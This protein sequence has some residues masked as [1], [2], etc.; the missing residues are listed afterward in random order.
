MDFFDKFNGLSARI[1]RQRD[2]V[3]TE[4]VAKTAFVLPFLRSLGC[5]LF[6][7]SI[8]P[9]TKT[10]DRV[11]PLAHAGCLNFKKNRRGRVGFSAQSWIWPGYS[12]LICLA[13]IK[14]ISLLRLSSATVIPIVFLS[15]IDYGILSLS[16]ATP[17]PGGRV[18][19]NE[20]SKFVIRDS[21][22]QGALCA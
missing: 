13:W 22:R 1:Q 21:V 7:P 20:A 11:L 5:D 17:L 14:N 6:N 3:L 10:G 15:I 19:I 12:I 2:S 4:Q 16:W 8:I 18:G 9:S